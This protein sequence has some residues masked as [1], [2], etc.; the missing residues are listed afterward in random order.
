MT[1][2]V[3][4]LRCRKGRR[5]LALAKCNWTSF[6][7]ERVNLSANGTLRRYLRAKTHIPRWP[8]NWKKSLRFY[9]KTSMRASRSLGRLY[10][11]KF[12]THWTSTKMVCGASCVTLVCYISNARSYISPT[13]IW[14]FPEPWLLCW[15]L[16]RKRQHLPPR[17]I[18]LYS[19]FVS[20]PNFWKRS[21][22]KSNTKL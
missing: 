20:S 15:L 8:R 12:R 1:I 13:V 11:P 19:C 4:S 6:R 18:V 5:A 16:W 17:T 14:D 21:C 7:Q 22:R 3:S 10:E 2:R 9:G